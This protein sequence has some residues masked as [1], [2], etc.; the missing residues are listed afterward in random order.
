MKAMQVA[1]KIGTPALVNPPPIAQ[2]QKA[3]RQGGGPL[4]A[5][6]IPPTMKAMI[7]G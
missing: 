5:S 1:G 6:A 2:E 3:E 7:W 4:H